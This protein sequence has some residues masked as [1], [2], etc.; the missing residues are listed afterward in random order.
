[1]KYVRLKES[2]DAWLLPMIDGVDTIELDSDGPVIVAHPGDWIVKDSDGELTAYSPE[3]FKR[4]FG[5]PDQ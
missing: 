3:D 4:K 5:M 1:M 2:V